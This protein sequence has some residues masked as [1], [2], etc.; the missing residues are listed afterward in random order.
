MTEQY[1]VQALCLTF[2]TKE[3]AQAVAELL[4]NAFLDAPDL[5]GDAAMICNVEQVD[6]MGEP[7]ND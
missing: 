1:R 3:K 4:T 7:I 2:E 5:T 6:D